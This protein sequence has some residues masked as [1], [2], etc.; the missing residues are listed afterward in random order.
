[1]LYKFMKKY[2]ERK[3]NGKHDGYAKNTKW[4]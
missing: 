3:N 2:K 1:M 4:W